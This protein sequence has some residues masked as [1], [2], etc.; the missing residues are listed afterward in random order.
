MCQWCHL[1]S[2][3]PDDL[4]QIMRTFFSEYPQGAVFRYR[5]DVI[6]LGSETPLEFPL[7]RMRESLNLGTGLAEKLVQLGIFDPEVL[8]GFY[9]GDRD[10]MLRLAGPGPMNTDDRPLLEYSAPKSLFADSTPVLEMLSREAPL[11]PPG[12]EP[13]DDLIFYSLIGKIKALVPVPLEQAKKLLSGRASPLYD[14]LTILAAMESSD[15]KVRLQLKT[16]NSQ[17]NLELGTWYLQKMMPTESLEAF[18]KVLATPFPGSSYSALLGAGDAARILKR[19][20]EAASYY[21]QS[22]PK[23][24]SSEPLVKLA[25]VQRVIGTDDQAIQTLDEAL[26]RHP[27]DFQAYVDRAWIKLDRNQVE[28][29]RADFQSATD[30]GAVGPSWEELARRLGAR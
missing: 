25:K 18:K 27:Y 1:Y 16:Q 13:S 30:L 15:D 7:K 17:A 20:K 26:Q 19:E 21:E 23:T 22:V 8:L 11:L 28:A 5:G 29:A 3:S 10:V 6:M 4:R 24:L 12:L 14:Y 9:A 2:T